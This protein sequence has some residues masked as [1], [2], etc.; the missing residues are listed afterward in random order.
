MKSQPIALLTLLLTPLLIGTVLYDSFSTG[1]QIFPEPI[2]SFLQG[3]L[4]VTFLAG[5]YLILTSKIRWNHESGC[6]HIDINYGK[7]KSYE[8]TEKIY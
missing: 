1:V 5:L 3:F 7:A 4:G 8:S 6:I 2:L